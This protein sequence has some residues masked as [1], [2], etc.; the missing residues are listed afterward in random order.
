MEHK[1]APMETFSKHENLGDEGLSKLLEHLMQPNEATHS[2]DQV[3]DCIFWQ[4]SRRHGRNS[5]P[6][7]VPTKE[8]LPLA[9]SL[10]I[11]LVEPG[12]S[13]HAVREVRGDRARVSLQ[14]W[15]HAPSLEQTLNYQKRGLATLQQILET[16]NGAGSNEVNAA[17]GDIEVG[18]VTQDDF[19]AL[20]KWI[21]PAYLDPQQLE[22]Q[23]CFP[24][25]LAQI[26]SCL[27]FAC[28][29]A[30]RGRRCLEQDY[31]LAV[32]HCLTLAQMQRAD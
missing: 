26:G 21:S 16:R 7:S 12:V 13:Y 28:A 14:G 19:K 17:N 22:D 20:S 23:R 18:Q 4:K 9:D 27:L 1:E 30:L 8:L 3:P 32:L 6:A 5:Q 2:E 24:L 29:L 25:T 11:F 15:L 10:A 31:P